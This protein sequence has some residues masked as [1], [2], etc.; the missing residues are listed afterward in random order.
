MDFKTLKKKFLT[1]LHNNNIG[2]AEEYLEEIEKK[3]PL[4]PEISDFRIL[5]TKKLFN[6]KYQLEPAEKVTFSQ[7]LPGA[8]FIISIV[9]AVVMIGAFVYGGTRWYQHMQEAQQ[10][11]E[12]S[13]TIEQYIEQARQAKDDGQY[14][15][16]LSSLNEAASIE[17]GN[18]EIQQMKG[19]VL[20]LI[21]E[22]YFEKEAYSDAVSYYRNALS[23]N[24][25]NL[26]YAIR[27]AI[28]YYRLARARGNPR[29]Y[30]DAL[31]PLQH[32]ESRGIVSGELYLRKG[33]IYIRMGNVEEAITNWQKTVEEFPD[34]EYVQDAQANLQQ[35]GF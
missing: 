27:L 14:R 3:F 18:P 2:G 16:A 20:F 24:R 1:A 5:F 17:S 21:G 30:Q 8:K 13:T 10:A 23:Y 6:K 9:L 35:Y 32:M 7:L 33:Y 25:D 12:I 11:Q 22:D 31:E 28:S 26:D 29:H 15:R 4:S 19:A 34:S